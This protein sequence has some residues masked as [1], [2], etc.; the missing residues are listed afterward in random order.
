M[1]K[2]FLKQY[3]LGCLLG[4][5]AFQKENSLPENSLTT[6]HVIMDHKIGISA[7]L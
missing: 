1:N 7:F 5:M 4:P 2:D 3:N 6:F